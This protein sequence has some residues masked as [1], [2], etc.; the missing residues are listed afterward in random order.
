[1]KKV[2]LK[3]LLLLLAM[4]MALSF[5]A[6]SN[7]DGDDTSTD[8]GNDTAGDGTNTEAP[9]ADSNNDPENLVLIKDSKALFRIVVTSEADASVIKSV[10]NFISDLQDIDVVIE[11]YVNDSDSANVTDCEIIVGT[12]AKNRDS[13]YSLNYRDYGEDGYEIK[14]VDNKVLIGGGNAAQTKSAF[15][16]FVKNVVKLTGKTKEMDELKLERSYTKLKETKYLIESVEIAGTDLSEYVFVTN[17]DLETNT[18]V[19]AF[20]EELYSATGYWLESVSEDSV[21]EGKKV[22]SVKNVA[23]AGETGFR[24]YVDS[25]KNFI[26]ECAYA[27]ATDIAFDHLVE[28]M[29]FEKIGNVTVSK[30]YKKSYPV[31]VV[32]YAQFGAVGDGVTE[33]YNAIR[34][35]HTFA[36]ISGQKVMGDGPDAT[37]YIHAIPSAVTVKTDVDWNGAKFHLDD[38]GSE[39]HNQRSSIF[40]IS[41]SH[42]VKTYNEQQIKEKFGTD[43]DLHFGDTEIPWLVGEIEVTSFVYIKNN[44]KDYIRHGGNISSGQNRRDIFVI[45]PDGKL[46]ED[47]PIIWDFVAGDQILNNGLKL[48]VV[49]TPAIS[50][51]RIYRADETPI[52][53]ENGFFERDACEVVAE[54]GF[55]NKY[56]GYGRGIGISRCNVTLQNLHNKIVTEPYLPTSGHGRGDDGK[57]RHSYP[58]SGFL[59]FNMCYNSKAINCDLNAHTAYF[60]DKTTSATPIAM[61]SYDLQCTNATNIYLEGLTN[62]VDHC[63]KQY[64]GIMVSNGSKNMTFKGCTLNRFDAHEGFWN[65][66]LIDSDYGHTINVIG[67]GKFYCENV[68]KNVGQTFISLRGDYGS[69]F[70][71]TIELINCTLKGLQSY[72]G[73]DDVKRGVPYSN[74]TEMTV[75][76]G[77]Y[78]DVYKGEYQEGNAAAFP[79]LKWDFGYTCYM[80]QHIILDNFVFEHGK[81]NVLFNVGDACFV[82]PDDFIQETDYA[83]KTINGRPMTED[84]IYYNQYQITKSLTFKNM[85]PIPVCSNENSYLFETL[86]AIAK[87]EE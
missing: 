17:V 83:G 51:M 3:L 52:T 27:N 60:E 50:E 59:T 57:L 35:A 78:S 24:A 42:K 62:G 49:S 25:D 84:D 7:D 79:Y 23:D 54:T 37:Y 48:E 61:G 10:E 70:N 67:G 45:E 11:K 81:P 87:V 4:S 26:I 39:V 43:I 56:V 76:S 20:R 85:K 71:G 2:I 46:H 38:R 14:V 9:P 63:D 64:W 68:V 47:T 69:T 58:Y 33:D 30:S 8:G 74:D 77:G 31:N 72:R 34:A 18:A 40:Q 55:E 86:T 22:F 12:G 80:P 65:A 28:E 13:K 16:Y 6:C 53:I 44:H 32:Y 21:P 19:N 1:M 82:K 29:I 73:P 5:T 75:I 66:S 15:D 36:N 41:P